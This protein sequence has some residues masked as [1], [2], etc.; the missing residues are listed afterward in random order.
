MIGADVSKG[1]IPPR[2]KRIKREHVFENQT[3][4]NLENGAHM[5]Y[6]PGD[7]RAGNYERSPETMERLKALGKRTY[8]KPLRS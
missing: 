2:L 1:R 6:V 8:E 4:K 5:R 7:T 3:V